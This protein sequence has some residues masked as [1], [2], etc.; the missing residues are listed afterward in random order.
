MLDVNDFIKERNGDPA[1]IKE[2]QRRRFAPEAVVDEVVEMF[3]DHR[4]TQYEAG[5]TMGARINKVP[6]GNG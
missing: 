3:E 5:T 2:S 4:K 6:E 1:K